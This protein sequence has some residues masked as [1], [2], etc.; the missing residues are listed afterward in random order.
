[1]ISIRF[2]QFFQIKKLQEFSTNKSFNELK[3]SPQIAELSSNMRAARN[4]LKEP[5]LYSR[6]KIFHIS[7]IVEPLFYW[8]MHFT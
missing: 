3:L 1:M 5:R 7:N 4:K 8:M 2:I 6:Y